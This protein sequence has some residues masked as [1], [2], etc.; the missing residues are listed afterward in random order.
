VAG[1]SETPVITARSAARL[2]ADLCAGDSAFT[3]RLLEPPASD[4]VSVTVLA[5][6]YFGAI[7]RTVTAAIWLGITT[8]YLTLTGTYAI[9]PQ[10]HGVE[11]TT[12]DAVP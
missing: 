5:P 8:G 11:V 1:R 4:Q 12:V 3:C 9:P 10:V 7:T 2:Q 6:P